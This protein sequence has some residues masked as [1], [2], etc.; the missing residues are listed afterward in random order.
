[1]PPTTAAAPGPLPR[2]RSSRPRAPAAS[3]TTRPGSGGPT[4]LGGTPGRTCTRT[5]CADRSVDVA[6]DRGGEPAGQPHHE[7]RAAGGREE[8]AD[9]APSERPRSTL[10]GTG[11]ETGS[12][13]GEGGNPADDRHDGG[14]ASAAT[15]AGPTGVTLGSDGALLVADQA[16]N[17]IRRSSG[18]LALTPHGRAA[19]A[20]RLRGGTPA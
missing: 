6:G 7:P 1:M 14:P 2:S 4:S 19:R 17:V 20:A 8:L 16:N 18:G 15:F 13:D 10:A 12:I 5:P 9:R 11:V 3:A